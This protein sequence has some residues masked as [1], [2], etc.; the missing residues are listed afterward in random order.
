MAMAHAWMKHSKS[1]KKAWEVHITWHRH[2]K[3]R[4]S[5]NH[6]IYEPWF[7]SRSSQFLDRQKS[8]IRNYLQKKMLFYA[9]AMCTIIIRM[10]NVLISNICDWKLI[11][12]LDTSNSVDLIPDLYSG[13]STLEYIITHPVSLDLF[14][15]DVLCV[16]KVLAQFM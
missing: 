5:V 11:V 3:K 8:Q 10:K 9:C 1:V 2:A 4:L 15:Q 12:N 14:S 7:Q 16:Q 6:L 13:Y